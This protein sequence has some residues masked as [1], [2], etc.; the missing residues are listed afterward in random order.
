[1]QSADR[2]CGQLEIISTAMQSSSKYAGP[3]HFT[4]GWKWLEIV[5]E[6]SEGCVK[7]MIDLYSAPL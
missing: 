7:R 2:N 6:T 3:T 1:M 5:P 4:C